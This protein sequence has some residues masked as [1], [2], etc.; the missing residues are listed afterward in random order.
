MRAIGI[1]KLLARFTPG[2]E[3]AYSR[4]LYATVRQGDVVW[5]VGANIGYYTT[6]LAELIGTQGKVFAFEP[7]PV[8]LEQLRANCEARHNVI[9]RGYGLSDGTREARLLEGSDE[10]RATSRV[11][12]SN[13]SIQGAI[14][15]QLRAGD[16]IVAKGEAESP[17][18]IKIDVEGHELGVLQGLR[19]YLSN[20]K[21]RGIFVEVHFGILDS[22]GHAKDAGL[23][24]T[25]LKQ[26]RFTIAWIDPSHIHASR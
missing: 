23:I 15:V 17:N 6:Q 4:Q 25:L 12:E 7:D 5:D 9:I 11:L 14:D 18:I 3:Q 16:E 24:E 19:A 22:I 21:L 13:S 10:L 2:Y 26:N 20:E 1:P 8:N